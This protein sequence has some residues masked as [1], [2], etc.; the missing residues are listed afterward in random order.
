MEEG[1]APVIE[2]DVVDRAVAAGETDCADVRAGEVIGAVGAHG[3]DFENFGMGKSS[4][5]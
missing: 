4:G 2:I 3:L 1:V 5:S